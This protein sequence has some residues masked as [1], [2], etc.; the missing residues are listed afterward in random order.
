MSTLNEKQI[1]S[2]DTFAKGVKKW[3]DSY[4]TGKGGARFFTERVSFGMV[5]DAL[6]DPT[7]IPKSDRDPVGRPSML[8]PVMNNTV[9]L[10]ERGFTKEVYQL[11]YP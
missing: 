9:Q 11:R 4:S 5:W 8:R 6:I 3:M 7:F 1:A 2:F 10:Q